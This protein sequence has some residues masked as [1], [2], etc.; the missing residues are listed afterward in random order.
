ML[1]AVL[2]LL[3]C[4][5]ATTHESRPAN[6]EEVIARLK[7]IH[8]PELNLSQDP[9]LEILRDFQALAKYTKNPVLISLN[10]IYDVQ[11]K[12]QEEWIA[13]R[14]PVPRPYPTHASFTGWEPAW[15]VYH[16]STISLYVKDITLDQAL[17]LVCGYRLGW[18]IEMGSILVYFKPIQDTLCQNCRI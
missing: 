5:C 9:I 4:G 14:K 11:N 13:I 7:R 18:K 2:S 16:C 17:S 1:C 15:P 10:P 3:V 8:I 6:S 12:S